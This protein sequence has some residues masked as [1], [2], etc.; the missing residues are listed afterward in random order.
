VVSRLSGILRVHAGHWGC[1]GYIYLECYTDQYL[2]TVTSTGACVSMRVIKVSFNSN[3]CQALINQ[4][5]A[6]G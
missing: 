5:L 3:L 4:M 6:G 2:L 1:T